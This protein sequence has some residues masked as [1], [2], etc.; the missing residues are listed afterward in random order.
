MRKPAIFSPK[1]IELLSHRLT[2]PDAL[3]D[4]LLDDPDDELAR[5]ATI[6]N[7]EPVAIA[8]TNLLG[9]IESRMP[10]AQL[11]AT[12]TPL[13]RWILTDVI[14]GSTYVACHP[15]HMVNM[16]RIVVRTARNT[17]SKLRAAGLDVGNVPEY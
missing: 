7:G 16:R 8:C 9:K 13:E 2:V 3:C 5:W 11:V 1:E 10:V 12:A 15:E 6:N 17:V 4:V 14:E